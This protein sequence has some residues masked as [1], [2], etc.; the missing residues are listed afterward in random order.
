[1]SEQTES[2]VSSLR[3][4]LALA[5]RRMTWARVLMGVVLL[6]LVL[7][8]LWL[9]L[10]ALEAALWLPTGLR[11]ALF[12]LF[13]GT[14]LGG[15]LYWIARPF[16]QRPTVEEGAKR[17]GERFPEVSDR[18]LNLLHLSEGRHSEA[19]N[20]LLEAA[21]QRL[22]TEVA[23]V[24]FERVEDFHEPKRLSK[25]LA[26][27]AA[28]LALFLALS[29]QSFLEA[30]HRLWSPGV[31]FERPA[32]FHF[33]IRPG[34]TKVVKGASLPISAKTYGSIMPVKA[35]L[36]MGLVD[37][38]HTEH[39]PLS[40]DA[41]GRFQHMMANIRQTTRYRFVSDEVQS[42]WFT[43]E[44]MDRPAVRQLNVHLNPPGYSG[45]Q[46]QT[47]EGNVGDV[48]GLPGTSVSLNVQLSRPDVTEA[49]LLF[50]DGSTV[51]LSVDG[52]RASGGFTIRKDGSYQ[53]LLRTRDQITNDNPISYAISTLR[54]EQPTVSIVTPSPDE[55]LTESMRVRVLA[56]TTDD[57]GF[58]KAAL[59]WRLAQR[60][61][62]A[63]MAQ[64]KCIGLGIQNRVLDQEL[65]Y[66]WL[67][68][69]STGIEFREGDV[70][71]YFVQVWDNNS[72]AGYQTARSSIQTLRLPSLT[73][74]YKQLEE[75]SDRIENQIQDMQNGSS[76]MRDMF[77]QL[78]E[79]LRQKQAPE[80]DD[81][82]NLQRMMEERREMDQQVQ[83][84]KEAFQ[85]LNQQ[86]Q[87][88]NL[89]DDKTLEMFREMERIAQELNTPEMLEAL[90]RL[91]EAMRQMN[92]Q[93]M[94]QA[95]QQFQMNERSFQQR[96][97]RMK[98]LFKQLKVQ[99]KMDELQNRAEEMADKQDRLADQIEEMQKD[100]KLDT[101]EQQ[102]MNELAEE[103]ARNRDVM[104]QMEQEMNELNEQMEELKN[105]PK[106]EMKEL[107]KDM[108]RE[109]MSQKMEQNKQD[110]QNGKAQQAKQN[111]RNMS[112]KLRSMAQQM[113]QM[114]EQNQQEQ[115]QM[116]IEALRRAL[117]DVLTLSR[118]QENLRNS[119][120]NLQS[121][122][123]RVRR[124]AQQQSELGDGLRILGDSL[125]TLSKR[126]P[127]MNKKIQEEATHAQGE[128]AQTISM[129]TERQVAIA[130]GNQKAA[131][132]H[133]NE[134][135]LL[136]SELLSQMQAQAGPGSMSMQQMM[137]MMQQMSQQQQRINQQIQQ[138]LN[139]M[140]GN[141]MSQ[142]QQERLNQLSAQQEAIRRQLDQLMNNPE[143]RSKVLGDM[144]KVSEDMQQTVQDM[145]R[146]NV[147]RETVLRQNQ[148]L[149]RLLEATRSL[150]TRGREEKR[151][152]ERAKEQN[153]QTP[154]Q[155][156][157]QDRATQIRRD[158][159]RAIETGYAPD[160]ERLIRKYFE[161]LQQ[162]QE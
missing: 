39:I 11:T 138:M 140:M 18:L 114:Q 124:I 77:N 145:R 24:P 19:P 97:E 44:V 104:R 64:S 43:I 52:D 133:L 91:Q 36:E 31:F 7:G 68:P 107:N 119:T 76:D 65:Q 75:Q 98:E 156:R 161:R 123:P 42:P 108:Q 96:L 158:L 79:Q 22:G 154:N 10:A 49:N 47:L 148:I 106:E 93:M 113:Q 149:S 69:E 137:D 67:L 60:Q 87:E 59:C 141:R 50:Q 99:Q 71:E 88:Q 37:E 35:T 136:L 13:L 102:R 8:S 66:E 15:L 32:R 122:N 142:S 26:I 63:P 101:Q 80:W 155:L 125:L 135:A 33:T 146:N 34:N 9:I 48:V 58:S 78:Q 128:M 127:K 132:T 94:E 144:K 100:G 5:L 40:A 57:Y 51:P 2:L 27:P 14:A 152:S 23:P 55:Q 62:G 95:M 16:W 38:D 20:P 46:A 1:M 28:V 112:Q 129:L 4:R 53:I 81:Q 30:S 139:Q 17:I 121:D 159:I 92:P 84:L 120:Q 12:V 41:D 54:D 72:V 73:Q 109:K 151:Q 162:G 103:Q 56:R 157:P 117:D 150:N 61:E 21:V 110:M 134:L 160:Y 118:E 3:N 105:A 143:F 45:L 130:T 74:Q 116:N 111:Q 70:I 86:M 89:V 147:T 153:Q 85:E 126:V 25:W 6:S 29:P 90:R 115:V 83:D 82:R 131:M